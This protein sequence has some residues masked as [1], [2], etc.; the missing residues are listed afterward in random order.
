[1]KSAVAL[2]ILF[3]VVMLGGWVAN[4]IKLVGTGFTV[5]QWGGMEVARVI[6]VFVPPLGA[7]LGFC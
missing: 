3:A 7:V 6:G 2:Y 1:M 5:A 4:I